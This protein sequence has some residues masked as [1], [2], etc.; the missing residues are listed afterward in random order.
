MPLKATIS[1]LYIAVCAQIAH[2]DPTAIFFHTLLSLILHTS[3]VYNEVVKGL[4]TVPLVRVSGLG[5]LGSWVWG[6]WWNQ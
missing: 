5:R 4:M 6:G 2:W 1:V 3:K